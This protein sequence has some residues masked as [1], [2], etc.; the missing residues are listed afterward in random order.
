MEGS[1]RKD[2]PVQYCEQEGFKRD[3][4]IEDLEA[5]SHLRERGSLISSIM[6]DILYIYKVRPFRPYIFSNYYNPDTIDPSSYSP[7]RSP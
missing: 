4:D 2:M 6:P 1:A 3:T 7:V 5:R